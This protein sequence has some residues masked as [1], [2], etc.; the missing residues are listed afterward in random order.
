MTNQESKENREVQPD[1]WHGCYDDSWQG[2]IVPE[3]FS[4]PAKMSYNLTRRIFK[5]ALF[6][7]W[8]KPGQVVCDPF[9]GIGSTGLIGA[10]FG[11]QVI[12]VELKQ[13]FVDLA[14]QNFERH[15]KSIESFSHFGKP[16]FPVIIQG[17]SRRL[18]EIISKVNLIVSSPPFSNTEG[19]ADDNFRYHGKKLGTTG[20]HYGESEGQLGNKQDQTFWQAAKI[21]VEQCHQILKPGGM[22]IWVVKA[23]VRNKK[24]VDFP[25]DWRRLCESIGFE[26]VCEHHAMLVKETRETGIFGDEIIK[27]KERKSFFRRLAENKGSPKID[28]EVV[29]CCQKMI[30]A[31]EDNSIKGV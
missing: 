6:E 8:I 17:D 25:G 15:R 3:A 30:K 4:H 22:A 12:C 11:L 5:H 2:L 18:S 1:S 13:K 16:L 21:I 9:G 7:G 23:F 20:K 28:F 24:K 29:L 26:T 19:T 31:T 27:K 10:H 14:R